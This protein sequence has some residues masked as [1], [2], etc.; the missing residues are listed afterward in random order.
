MKSKTLV[1]VA[2][3]LSVQLSFA[4]QKNQLTNRVNLVFGVGQILGDGFNVEGNIFYKRFAFDYSHGTSLNT[5]NSF[6]EEGADK[7]QGLAIH[8]PWTTGFGVG[9]RFNDWLNL[10]FEPKWHKYELYYDGESQNS[11]NQ[12]AEY[13]TTTLGLGLYANFRPFKNKNNLLKGIMIAPNIRWWPRV[14]STLNNDELSYFNTQLNENVT[15]NAREIGMANTPFFF[16]CSV[17]YTIQ[18]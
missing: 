16:N 15:H 12:I 7:Q 6:L 13:V 4:Q 8:I 3:M 9:Y 17:G 5:P 14:S 1:A 2:F 10:R 11:Q 18:F